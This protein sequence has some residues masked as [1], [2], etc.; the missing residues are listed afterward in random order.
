[1][2]DGLAK[3][4]DNLEIT[5]TPGLKAEGE[6]IAV[7]FMGVCFYSQEDAM[8]YV[9]ARCNRAFGVSP[10][11]LMDCYSIFYFLNKEIFVTRNKLN[12]TDLHKVHTLGMPQADVFHILAS[13]EHG[14]PD[15]F[16][17]PASFIKMY[18]D[19]RQG[20]KKHQ[21]GNIGTH[22]IWG[23]IGA[24]I[25]SVRKQADN[26]LARYVTTKKLMFGKDLH[27]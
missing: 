13:V 7:S 21:F 25:N 3:R 11:M 26:V 17:S 10:G 16:D 1:M 23:P 19:G 12:V 8:A 22:E 4:V 15:F 27:H 2:V 5:V 6:N 9:E 14:L 20:T 18:I 24:D